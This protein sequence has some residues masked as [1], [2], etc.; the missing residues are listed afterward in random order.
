MEV[1][2]QILL[3]GAERYLT[4]FELGYWGKNLASADFAGTV[5]GRLRFYR[6]DGSNFNGYATPGTLLYDSGDFSVATTPRATLVFED[7]QL[8]A[9]VPLT[10]ALPDNFTWSFQFSGMAPGDRAGLDIFTPPVVG[11][12]YEDYWERANSTSAWI[13]KTNLNVPSMDFAARARASRA[14]YI[15]AVTL[16]SG[17]NQTGCGEAGVAWRAWQAFDPCGNSSICT[18]YVSVVD[19]RPP[20]LVCPTDKAVECGTAWSFGVPTYSDACIFSTMA[21]DNSQTNTGY[22]LNPNDPTRWK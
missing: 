16:A 1:G 13:L 12:S 21:F 18:Q 2:D 22:R 15:R 8:D 11:N 3:A 9:A 19:T 17:T 4:K 7:F 14:G 6:N 20:S 5:K 10:N